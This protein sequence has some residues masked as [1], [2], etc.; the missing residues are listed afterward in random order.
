MKHESK[1]KIH[2]GLDENRVPEK[3]EW[4]AEDG[5]QRKSET[6]AILLSVW[7][8]AT[9][10][11]LRIDLWTKEMRVDEMKKLIHQTMLGLADTLERS[12][13]EEKMAGDMRDFARYYAEK[14]DLIQKPK[15]Q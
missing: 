14:L 11:T 3:L 10:N 9:E 4:E 5:G 6:K 15:D 8:E 12:A 1:I 13:N 2:V 7:E